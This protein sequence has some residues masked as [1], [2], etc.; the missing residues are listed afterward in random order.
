MVKYHVCPVVGVIQGVPFNPVEVPLGLALGFL[1]VS[2]HRQ[3]H[4]KFDL[5]I[6]L[7]IWVVPTLDHE[8]SVDILKD[9][10]S[11]D[12]IGMGQHDLG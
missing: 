1:Y 4:L 9:V 12:K 10:E 7:Y 6:L 2:D 8:Q 11:I 3:E 5:I